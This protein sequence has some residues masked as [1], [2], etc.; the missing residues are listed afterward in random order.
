MSAPLDTEEVLEGQAD[1]KVSQPGEE[2]KD[3]TDEPKKKG[4]SKGVKIFLI[5]LVIAI[6]LGGIAL[7]LYFFVF[8]KTTLTFSLVSSSTTIPSGTPAAVSITSLPATLFGYFKLSKGSYASGTATY[9]NQT[10]ATIASPSSITTDGKGNYWFPLSL[11]QFSSQSI[12]AAPV[13]LTLT[14]SSG[15]QITQS[16]NNTLLISSSPQVIAQSPYTEGQQYTEYLV[17]PSATDLKTSA[18]NYPDLLQ[19]PKTNLQIGASSLSGSMNFTTTYNLSAGNA[20]SGFSIIINNTCQVPTD[21]YPIKITTS[22]G[23]KCWNGTVYSNLLSASSCNGSLF[24]AFPDY[25]TGSGPFLAASQ[26]TYVITLNNS[27]GC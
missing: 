7:L 23:N 8:N 14:E 13:T 1:V 10:V 15:K 3:L 20:Y 11:N 2:T 12:A 9:N 17:G 22:S 27:S 24:M 18:Y 6:I 5:V 26:G 4:L 25:S 16:S 21:A 19:T